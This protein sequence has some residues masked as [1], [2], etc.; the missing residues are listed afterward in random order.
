MPVTPR[1]FQLGRRGNG[2]NV[3]VAYK[4]P[5][6]DNGT[7]DVHDLGTALIAFGDLISECN[8]T[9]NHDDSKVAVRVNADFKT[10]SFEIGLEIYRS[11]AAQMQSFFDDTVSIQDIALYVGLASGAASLIGVSL[12]DF[13]KWVRGRPIDKAKNNADG[14]S[15]IIIG[16]ENVTIHQNILNLYTSVPV[17]DSLGKVLAPLDKDGID[18]FETRDSSG[19]VVSKVNKDEKPYFGVDEEDKEYTSTSRQDVLVKILN[20]SFEDLKWRLLFGNDKIYADIKDENF[21]ADVR[22]G[23]IAFASGD[24]LS[25]CLEIH[26]VANK[27]II[28]TNYSVLKVNRVLQRPRE[29]ML[30]FDEDS[31]Q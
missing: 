6:V 31:Q 14:T 25:V 18:S 8:K 24:V 11:I 1:L 13:I 21:A 30:P 3:I 28:K 17:Q 4:G 9:L 2:M 23:R 12:I 22:E 7:M 26:Q 16:D 10:G 19:N 15:T 5:L 27:G 29:I 20:V